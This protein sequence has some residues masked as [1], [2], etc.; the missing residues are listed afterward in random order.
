[1]MQNFFSQVKRKVFLGGEARFGSGSSADNNSSPE[2]STQKILL[3][4][5]SP[6]KG[7]LELTDISKKDTV[8]DKKK[9]KKVLT[10]KQKEKLK[11][12]LSKINFDDPKLRNSYLLNRPKGKQRTNIYIKLFIGWRLIKACFHVIAFNRL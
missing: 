5:G 10:Q 6:I 12:K 9:K 2:K 11:R 7:G 8:Q 3:Q 4:N 1:M